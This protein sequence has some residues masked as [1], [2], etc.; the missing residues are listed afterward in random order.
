MRSPWCSGWAADTTA[1][2][3]GL[4]S[5]VHLHIACFCLFGQQLR[6]SHAAADWPSHAAAEPV[7]FSYPTPLAAPG[8]FI[9]CLVLSVARCVL[10][11]GFTESLVA[12]GNDW[13]A[14][15]ISY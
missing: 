3:S 7:Q 11:A 14:S 10:L 1:T 15:I 8:M 4:Y 2:V 6:P 13:K 12:D 9:Y 5:S